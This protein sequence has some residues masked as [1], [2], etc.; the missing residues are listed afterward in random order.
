MHEWCWPTRSKWGQMC[1]AAMLE[2]FPMEVSSTA[3]VLV[4]FFTS[5]VYHRAQKNLQMISKT[6]LS[7]KWSQLIRWN[8][9]SSV[10]LTEN[11]QATFHQWFTWKSA[12]WSSTIIHK[13]SG[14]SATCDSWVEQP[15]W[16]ST[17]YQH[18]CR[19]TLSKISTFLMCNIK[20]AHVG[21]E[22]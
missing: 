12:N 18:S 5:H 10:V 13:K 2:N 6:Q 1:T 8:S 20:F 7:L 21:K 16:S 4:P 9:R 22:I 11:Q 17:S 19:V 3:D 14:S 15:S